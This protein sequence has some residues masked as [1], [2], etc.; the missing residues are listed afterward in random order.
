M[1]SNKNNANR[2]NTAVKSYLFNLPFAILIIVIYSIYLI[3]VI[4]YSN[5]LISFIPG[6]TITDIVVLLIIFPLIG[7][8]LIIFTPITAIG[9]YNIYFMV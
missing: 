3:V 1:D 8:I 4:S 5:E 2:Y 6:S 7:F 9:Y